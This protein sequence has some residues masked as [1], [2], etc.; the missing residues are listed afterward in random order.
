MKNYKNYNYGGENKENNRFSQNKN[1][2]IH[3]QL[4]NKV[5]SLDIPL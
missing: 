5:K 3:N 4:Q 1:R 2:K